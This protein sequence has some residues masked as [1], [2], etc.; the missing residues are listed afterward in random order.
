MNTTIRNLLVS[1]HIYHSADSMIGNN[2]D[3]HRR[4]YIYYLF[5]ILITN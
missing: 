3:V 4:L 1:I 5:I 2:V